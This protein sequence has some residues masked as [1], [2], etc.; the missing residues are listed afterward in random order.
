ML[1][2]PNF[3][4]IIANARQSKFSLHHSQCSP[5]QIFSSSSPMLTNP[6]FLLIIHNARQSKFSL[7]HPQCSPIQIF[8]SSFTMLAN[9]KFTMLANPNFLLIIHNARQSKLLVSDRA[10]GEARAS[11]PSN[12]SSRALS[13]TVL[14]AGRNRIGSSGRQPSETLEA[15]RST[16]ISEG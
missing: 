8:S 3:L 16:R 1:A 2:N 15:S 6:N 14:I 5:I 12:S 7:H 13:Q 11:Q 9:P 10:A 4:F